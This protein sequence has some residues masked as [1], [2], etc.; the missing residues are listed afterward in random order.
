MA[1]GI[2]SNSDQ[3]VDSVALWADGDLG[4]AAFVGAQKPFRRLVSWVIIGQI[5]E[6]DQYQIMYAT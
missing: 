3:F 2:G 4:A 5:Q 6:C 1:D